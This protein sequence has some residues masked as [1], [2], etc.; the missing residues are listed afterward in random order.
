MKEF[1]VTVQ[2]TAKGR[3]NASKEFGTTPKIFPQYIKLF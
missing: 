2:Q 3:Y 1:V